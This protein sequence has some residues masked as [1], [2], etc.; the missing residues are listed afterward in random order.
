MAENSNDD[1]PSSGEPIEGEAVEPAP[2]ESGGTSS[3]EGRRRR[4]AAELTVKGTFQFSGPLPPPDILK[5]YNGAFAGCAERVIA[6]A[7]RQSAHRQELEKM[8]VQGNCDAQ[9]R[10]TMVRFYSCPT[11]FGGGVYLLAQGKSII[12]FSAIILAVGSL[13]GALIYGRSEQRKEREDKSRKLPQ[14]RMLPNSLDPN[15]N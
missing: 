11:C 15:S 8:V 1:S 2:E 12:G 13:I 5:A 9:S 6:M 4:A 3:A 14:A 10:G 7:E